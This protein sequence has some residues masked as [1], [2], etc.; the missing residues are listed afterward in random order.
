[1]ENCLKSKLIL[2]ILLWHA[3]AFTAQDS[4]RIDVHLNPDSTALNIHFKHKNII[5]QDIQNSLKKGVTVGMEH[6]VIL[7]EKGFLAN[8][9]ITERQIRYKIQYD[10][11]DKLFF[12]RNSQGDSCYVSSFNDEQCCLYLQDLEMAKIEELDSNAICRITIEIIL[13]PLSLDNFSEVN[14]WFRGEI[15][16][17][18]PENISTTSS[19][20]KKISGW[21]LKLLVNMSGFG[22]RITRLKSPKF[23]YNNHQLLFIED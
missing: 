17:M 6:K 20:G 5:H 22:D 8:K 13:H 14:R 19:P 18:H 3:A 1:M 15:T 10:H 7:W 9:I 11:W 21:M 12:I 16:K 2:L 4:T 23:Q